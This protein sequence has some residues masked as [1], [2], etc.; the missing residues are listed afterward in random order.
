[1][2]FNQLDQFRRGW[3]G[4]IGKGLNWL[5]WIH[6]D[7][8]VGIIQYLLEHDTLE[9]PFNLSAPQPIQ[10]RDYARFLGGIVDK[11]VKQRTPELYIRLSMGK[12]ADMV[13]HNRR[14]IPTRILESGYRFQHPEAQ[15]AL[16]NL[17]PKT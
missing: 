6:I 1:M 5:P 7:D 4:V 3:G 15:E 17:F 11:P 14:M 16:M 2:A 13:V 10:Y 8:E 12:A 9:G